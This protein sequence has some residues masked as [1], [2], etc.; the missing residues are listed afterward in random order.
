MR[1]H[2]AF[3]AVTL[4]GC[5]GSGDSTPPVAAPSY[6]TWCRCEALQ[7]PIATLRV[8]SEPVPFTDS[9]YSVVR[10]GMEFDVVVEGAL[11][12]PSNGSVPAPSTRFRARQYIANSNGNPIVATTTWSDP[13]YTHV[14]QGQRLLTSL[15]GVDPDVPNRF[16]VGILAT[17]SDAGTL[18]AQLFSFPAGTSVEQMLDPVQWTCTATAPQLGDCSPGDAGIADAATD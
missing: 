5:S 13:L 11:P 14:V 7:W 1:T 4:L 9:R 16:S 8:D 12:F 15:L 3:L 2:L 10:T 18:P 17:V 6:V